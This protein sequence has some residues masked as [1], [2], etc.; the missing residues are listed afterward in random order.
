M[1][2]GHQT[3]LV[4]GASRGIGRA[5]AAE[6]V[7]AGFF[8][9]LA[10][11]SVG[12]LESAVAELG[13]DNATALGLDV[14]DEA[15]CAAAV[16]ECE[17]SY[18]GVEVLVNNAG[19]ARSKPFI[20]TDTELWR[21]LM[22]VNVEGPFWLTRAALPGMLERGRGAVVT[23]ASLAARRGYP[24]I[25]AYA[26]SKHA[27]LGMMRALAAEHARSGV[28]F[29]CVCPSYVDSPMTEESIAN[30]VAQ[31]GRDRETAVAPLLSPQ[32]RLVEVDE[33]AAMVRHLATRPGRGINGQAIN[34]DGGEHQG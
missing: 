3:A 14:A 30:I 15:A 13:A 10:A 23:V 22:R 20:A 32:G 24:Y 2:G 19:I 7:A 33:V 31:T 9:V 6:L 17:S 25:A 26:A 1:S 29:N 27:V 11:R 28:T 8:V 18:G 5:I 12:E 21:Q 34:I 16:A 4:T